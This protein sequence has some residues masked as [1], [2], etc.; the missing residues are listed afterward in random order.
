[1]EK[2]ALN[3]T[4]EELIEKS[5]DYQRQVEFRVMDKCPFIVQVGALT[6]ATTENGKVITQ[7]SN[8]PTQFT[9]TAVD[10]ILTMTFK[11][12]NG[13]VVIP[14][15]YSRVEWFQERLTEITETIGLFKTNVVKQN[16]G[17]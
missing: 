10:E 8:Y 4:L 17:N 13:G 1:M 9:Q 12:G 7:N 14:K 5:K 16:N 6:V 11:N 3:K 2:T 15:V